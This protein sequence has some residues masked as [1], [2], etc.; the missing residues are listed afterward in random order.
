[1][2]YRPIDGSRNENPPPLRYAVAFL[3]GDESRPLEL[4][5]AGPA[6]EVKARGLALK[7]GREAEASWLYSRLVGQWD[8]HLRELES[9]YLVPGG[10]LHL[11]NFERM[12]LPDGRYW[13]ERQRVHR[14]Q[15]ARDLLR[16]FPAAVRTGGLLALGG[17]DYGAAP[18]E[19]GNA[20][21][22]GDVHR[23][24]SSQVGK[25]FKPLP[26]S[27]KELTQ[28][29][30]FFWTME[31]G[32]SKE[33]K[34]TWRERSAAEHRLK[35]L[36][37][38]P[39]VL[40]FATHAFYLDDR[41]EVGRPMILSGLALANANRG[42]TGRADETGQ[43]GILYAL[44]AQ[45]LNLEGTQLVTLSACETGQGVVDY[46]EGIYGLVRA[47]RV[48][49]ARH[50]LMTLEKVSDEAAYHFMRRFYLAWLASGRLEHPY[51]ALRATKLT[52]IR[53]QAGSGHSPKLWAP[54]VLVEV[55]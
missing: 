17:I 44:E 34:R 18:G 11:V 52:Y 50:V 2:T 16:D 3:S 10:W 41:L 1:T 7:A 19:G 25:G 15:T 38:P 33:I 12:I 13:I 27:D 5:D 45:D 51:E 43:D 42:I 8:E 14:L 49:G 55:P 30:L 36:G 32:D 24:L 21:S 53:N 29:E 39:Q 9:V 47:F 31:E 20:D 4:R 6:G 22:I 54:F 46:A 23:N 28:L 26:A 37:Q 48:A 40:H 35:Q